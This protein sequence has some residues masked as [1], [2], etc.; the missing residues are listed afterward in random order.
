M[1]LDQSQFPNMS[2][3]LMKF[4]YAKELFKL[5]LMQ[6]VLGVYGR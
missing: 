5:P 4:F 1:Y 3:Q 2:N 6:I